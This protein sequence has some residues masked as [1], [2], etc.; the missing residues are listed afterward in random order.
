MVRKDTK[1]CTQSEK[2][3]LCLSVFAYQKLLNRKS[4]NRKS[5][6]SKSKIENE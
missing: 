1:S 2:K 5:K 3:T 4:V 6:I